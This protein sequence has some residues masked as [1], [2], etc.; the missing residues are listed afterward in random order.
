[1]AVLIF[2]IS[3]AICG[4]C[5]YLFLSRENFCNFN[6]NGI[7][8]L[9]AT[10]SNIQRLK[11]YSIKLQSKR[12]IKRRAKNIEKIRNSTQKISTK[13]I[14]NTDKAMLLSQK[15]SKEMARA[16]KRTIQTT[17]III[18]IICLIAMMS[19]SVF[20]IFFA[21]EKN[22]S[23]MINNGIK[24]EITLEKVIA[25]LNTEFIQKITKIQNENP[26]DE[27]EIKNRIA[28]YI[29]SQSSKN[30]AIDTMMRKYNKI[31]STL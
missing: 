6:K 27:Y 19:S 14:K 15:T 21:G 29:M 24:E 13:A 10:K 20:G 2:G 26:Y 28:D 1:M 8:N 5:N 7:N 9:K 31:I 17:I 4:S 22:R 25:D 23:Y 11:E 16:S 18:V 3:T 12:K 30:G